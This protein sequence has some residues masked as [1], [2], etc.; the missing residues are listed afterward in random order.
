MTAKMPAGYSEAYE[1]ARVLG[2]SY[3]KGRAI[4]ACNRRQCVGSWYGRNNLEDLLRATREETAIRWL[5]H[6]NAGGS[7]RSIHKTSKEHDREV[8]EYKETARTRK[9]EFELTLPMREQYLASRGDYLSLLTSTWPVD[10]SK[11]EQ[12][13][14][15]LYKKNGLAKPTCVWGASP[16]ESAKICAQTDKKPLNLAQTK[17][18]LAT[19][20]LYKCLQVHDYRLA[21][22]DFD[23]EDLKR[24]I[25]R[26]IR[27]QVGITNKNHDLWWNCYYNQFGTERFGIFLD[28][29]EVE[30]MVEKYQLREFMQ[31]FKY[32]G[33]YWTFDG[34]CVLTERPTEF[35]I[36]NEVGQRYQLHNENGPAVTYSDG[37]SVYVWHGITVPKHV[38]VEPELI[39]LK[40]IKRQRNAEIRRILLDRYGFERFITD[41]GAIP[42]HADRFGTLYHV[43][44]NNDETL[45]VVSVLNNTPE[46]G[47]ERKRYLLRVPPYIM[48]AKSAV[49]W[50]F[51]CLEKDYNPTQ[52]T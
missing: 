11:T 36:E 30:D 37:W 24:R 47:G 31:L 42:I 12:A 13:I 10:R 14:F 26:Q 17:L 1:L 48:T 16:L 52:E 3:A 34:L 21:L 40:S 15:S 46:P 18:S 38:I 45:A 8:R 22:Q 41:S 7:I 50:T 20:T 23:L 51:G 35:H 9:R 6:W 25:P 4:Y 27:Q 19:S 43:D 39:T 33:W 28:I 29:P 5:N 32:C 49:A 44:F 2:L